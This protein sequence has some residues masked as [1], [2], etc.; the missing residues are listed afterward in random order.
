MNGTGIDN[1]DIP[2][3]LVDKK[4]ILNLTTNAKQFVAVLHFFAI[5]VGS[6]VPERLHGSP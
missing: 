3:H 4:T 1:S 6:Q 5:V 2:H